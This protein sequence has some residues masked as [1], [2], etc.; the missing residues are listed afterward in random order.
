MIKWEPVRLTNEIGEE[1]IKKFYLGR[2]T[3]IRSTKNTARLKHG[4]VD[5]DY[6]GINFEIKFENK[7][8]KFLVID[9]F[10]FEKNLEG[11]LDFIK[12]EIE[13][14]NIFFK[15]ILKN[16]GNRRE[17]E[18]YKER[19]RY[20]KSEESLKEDSS[21]NKKRSVSLVYKVEEPLLNL[22]YD[23]F[24]ETT[25]SYALLPIFAWAYKRN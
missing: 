17:F 8:G 25:L 14:E 12:R 23:S 16:I 6:F 5:I 22:N 13:T 19:L 7:N 21:G 15:G 2:D 11:L 1:I 4:L 9:V 20:F 10:E 24:R 3:K 18:K